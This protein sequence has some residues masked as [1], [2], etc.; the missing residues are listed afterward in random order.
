M[1]KTTNETKEKICRFDLIGMKKNINWAV[2]VIVMIVGSILLNLLIVAY[3][4]KIANEKFSL[5]NDKKSIFSKFLNE[6]NKNIAKPL[7]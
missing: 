6:L 2:K 4:C 1:G 7:N 3:G 5:L